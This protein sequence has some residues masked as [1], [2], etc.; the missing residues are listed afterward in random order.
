MNPQ[1]QGIED[2]P[3]TY[4]FDVRASNRTLNLNRFLWLMIRADWRLRYRQ[5][6]QA[7]MA[8]AGLTEQEQAM[9]R[10][11]DWL[12][13]V[14]HGAN[15]FVV[16]KFV[17]VAQLSNMQVYAM[18]RGESYEDFLKTRRVPELR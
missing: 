5:D 14:Q 16:E 10:E 3:G 1:L 15:F 2:I 12:G 11:Q 18:M 8:E 4:V 6:P 7:L 13:L 17:R 9:A